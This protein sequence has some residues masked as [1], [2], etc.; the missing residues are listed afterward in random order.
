MYPSGT[1]LTNIY[2]GNFVKDNVMRVT[3]I[4]PG[5]HQLFRR[6]NLDVLGSLP[7]LRRSGHNRC[8]WTWLNP[9]HTRAGVAVPD[10]R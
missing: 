5:E 10:S 4:S 7:L 2:G 3:H 6:V 8:G 1:C 9:R